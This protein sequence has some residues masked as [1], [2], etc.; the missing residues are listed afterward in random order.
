[1]W[2]IPQILDSGR[3]AVHEW[4]ESFARG[5]ALDLGGPDAVTPAPGHDNFFEKRE[6]KSP[7]QG[8]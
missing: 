4:H 6:I 2:V 7:Q 1:M 3:R 8:L 5:R